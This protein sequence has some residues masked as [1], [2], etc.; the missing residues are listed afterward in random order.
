MSQLI[1]EAASLGA[2][3]VLFGNVVSCLLDF[4]ILSPKLKMKLPLLSNKD[5]FYEMGIVLFLTGVSI[6][7]FCELVGINRWYCRHG[8]ACRGKS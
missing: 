4:A 7:L 8:N 2:M 5:R 6:H 1:Y 3:T